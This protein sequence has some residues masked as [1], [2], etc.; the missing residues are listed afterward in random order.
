MHFSSSFGN[1]AY[2][3]Y[4]DQSGKVGDIFECPHFDGFEET[5]EAKSYL[6]DKGESLE[7]LGITSYEEVICENGQGGRHYYTDLSG[8]LNE[9]YPC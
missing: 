7:S 2:I 5:S 4:G 3:I 9:G 6:N 1:K 8:N